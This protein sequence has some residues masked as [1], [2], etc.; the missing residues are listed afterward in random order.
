MS[1]QFETRLAEWFMNR[2]A[3][4]PP[5]GGQKLL[6]EFHDFE[7][8]DVFAGSLMEMADEDAYP[9]IG[10]KKSRHS[11]LLFQR[12]A[13]RRILHESSRLSAMIPNRMKSLRDTQHRCET[14]PPVPSKPTN[15]GRS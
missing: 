6:V 5:Q 11:Q 10:D 8:T 7:T 13:S 1:E 3:D 2:L 9:V 14:K 15:H 4:T 12:V